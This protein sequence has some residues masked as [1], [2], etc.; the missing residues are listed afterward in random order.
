MVQLMNN[1][2]TKI[3]FI[4][5]VLWDLFGF[6]HFTHKPQNRVCPFAWHLHFEEFI[7]SKRQRLSHK[8]TLQSTVE[9]REK[10]GAT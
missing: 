5:S 1:C 8:P 2:D 3:K 10:L 9:S 4:L 6:N 7:F